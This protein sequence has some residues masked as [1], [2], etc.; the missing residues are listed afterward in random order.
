MTRRS[1]LAVCALVLAAAGCSSGAT[2]SADEPSTAAGTSASVRTLTRSATRTLTRTATPAAASGDSATRA[3]RPAHIVVVVEEN[4]AADEV[5][6]S[7]SAPFINSLAAGGAS[8]TDLYAIRH[9]SEPNYVALF[10]GSTHGLT[11][12]S[13][14]HR[15]SGPTLAGQLATA[16]RTFAGY[17]EGLPHTGYLGCSAGAYAR[18]HNPWSDVRTVDG[19]DNR[20]M[21]AFPSDYD[22]LPTVSF[23]VPDLDHD[24]HDGTVRQA[25][26]WLRS[27]LGAFARWATTHNSLLVVTWDED[28][29]SQGNRIPTILVGAHV[30]PGAYHQRTDLYGLL[31]TLTWLTGVPPIG[32]SAHRSPFAGLWT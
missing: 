27:H 25:D 13:C 4:H 20:P 2:P 23:V 7:R 1:A 21:T 8:M 19:A 31:R 28:D 3:P 16:G 9:P 22:R 5:L 15:F 24:M 32:A 30:R 11:D 18:K 26:S 6:G 14:P 10:S 29:H 17:S 12:D